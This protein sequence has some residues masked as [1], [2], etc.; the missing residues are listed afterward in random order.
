MIT[1]TSEVRDLA[2]RI[3]SCGRVRVPLAD[4]WQMWDA[5]APRLSGDPRQAAGMSEALSILSAAG[6]LELPVGAWDRSTSP[7]LP[8]SVVVPDSRPAV[9]QRNW[10]T[11]P[12]CQ[13]LG[14]VASLPTLTQSRFEHL[15]SINTWLVHHTGSDVPEVPM[16]YRSV[17]LFGDEKQLEAMVKTNLFGDGRLSL[18]MLFCVHLPPPLAAVRVGDGPDVLVVEN[19]DPY[20]VAVNALRSDIE[21]PVG[22]VV[23]GVGNQF[24]VHVPALTVDLAGHGPARGNVWYWGDLDP[25]GLAIAAESARESTRIGGPEIRPAQLLWAVMAKSTAQNVGQVDWS[26]SHAGREWLGTELTGDLD[27]VFETC[28]RVAQESV[29]GIAVREWAHSL[30]VS[31]P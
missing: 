8:R 1:R 4:L 16:R 18:E 9:R 17:E 11:Y 25:Q 13:Q 30:S 21:H 3:T 22:L 26:Q 7:P 28:S 2:Q 12:W 20:W 31:S 14:W 29:D 15:V 10:I 19:S 23:W 27:V 6:T 24:R 5:S